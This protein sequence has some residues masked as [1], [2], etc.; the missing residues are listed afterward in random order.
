ML[1]NKDM[2]LPDCAGRL[3]DLGFG[4]V[5]SPNYRL[6][7][8]IS[9]YDG[10]VLDSIDSYV[11]CQTELPRHLSDSADVRVDGSKIVTFG[12]SAGGTLTLLMVSRHFD[13]IRAPFNT[14]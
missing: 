4:A 10:A 2:L 13:I 1:G 8:T 12:H 5:V 3:L 14:Q 11:W 6:S 7:P 9:L